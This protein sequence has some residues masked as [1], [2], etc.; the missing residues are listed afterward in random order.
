MNS[1]KIN[2]KQTFYYICVCKLREKNVS[3]KNVNVITKLLSSQSRS[4]ETLISI[5]FRTQNSTQK[6]IQIV[7]SFGNF[8]LHFEDGEG[9]INLVNV[10]N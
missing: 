7:V 5:F 3:P 4:H 10:D 6:S 8:L 2:K 9:M 1:I